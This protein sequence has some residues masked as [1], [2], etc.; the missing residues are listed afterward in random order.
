M[1][2]YDWICFLALQIPFFPDKKHFQN[3]DVNPDGYN[4]F[5]WGLQRGK[6]TLW[7]RESGT[8]T[9]NSIGVLQGGKEQANLE[10]TSKILLPWADQETFS[11]ITM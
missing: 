11:L 2:L 1:S 9:V 10:G 5:H 3:G 6:V 8:G 7:G 4:Q